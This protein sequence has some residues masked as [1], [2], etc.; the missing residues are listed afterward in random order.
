[1]TMHTPMTI[2]ITDLLDAQFRNLREADAK[3][4][5]DESSAMAEVVAAA[6]EVAHAASIVLGKPIVVTPCVVTSPARL[7]VLD[8]KVHWLDPER[9]PT[10]GA[11]VLS[12]DIAFVVTRP[13]NANCEPLLSL[14]F[15]DGAWSTT[16]A[17]DE[18][19]ADAVSAVRAMFTRPA[20]AKRVANLLRALA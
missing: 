13:L 6:D 5:A 12:S 20:S 19:Y 15:R 7:V 2:N 10:T 18:K 17:T 1:M 16:D 11:D 8:K 14:R 9:R 4:A 3:R